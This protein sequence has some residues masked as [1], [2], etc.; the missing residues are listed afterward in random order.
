MDLKEWKKKT[1]DEQVAYFKALNKPE[2]QSHEVL[3]CDVEINQVKAW[4]E[5]V[6]AEEHDAAAH[7]REAADVLKKFSPDVI[8]IETVKIFEKMAS[9]EYSHFLNNKAIVDT[10]NNICRCKGS[11]E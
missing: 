4:L 3:C 6:I 8:G 1:P 9:E 10:L 2:S 5:G 11:Q 7:Y